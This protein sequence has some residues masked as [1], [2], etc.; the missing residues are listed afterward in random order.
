MIEQIKPIQEEGLKINKNANGTRYNETITI[1]LIT[2][3]AF[4]F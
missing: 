3:A 1:V 4:A 2:M